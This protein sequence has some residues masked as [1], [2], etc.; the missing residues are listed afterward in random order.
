MYGKT[1]PGEN[2]CIYLD[3]NT[4][5]F[6][7]RSQSFIDRLTVSF[8]SEKENQVAQVAELS[9]DFLA[10]NPLCGIRFDFP[11]NLYEDDPYSFP[12]GETVEKHRTYWSTKQ[13][14]LYT[15][16]DQCGTIEHIPAECQFCE[17]TGFSF[18]KQQIIKQKEINQN[19]KVE[20][21]YFGE[22]DC[23]KACAQRIGCEVYKQILF[24]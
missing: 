9:I 6:H 2:G 3:G 24:L 7:Q 16:S 20:A 15:Y 5:I 13:C 19:Q 14:A 10:E 8:E 11:I 17:T 1:C 18:R 4:I 21:L 12:V 22:E 23:M